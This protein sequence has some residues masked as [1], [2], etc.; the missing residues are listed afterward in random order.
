MLVKK[1]EVDMWNGLVVVL[2]LT[3]CSALGLPVLSH[4]T[5]KG[6]ELNLRGCDRCLQV[7]DLEV[8]RELDRMV[9]SGEISEQERLL[10]WQA[11]LARISSASREDPSYATK[12]SKFP[13][14]TG[15]GL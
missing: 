8:I 11:Y 3:V 13:V 4:A 14:F 1:G 15:P 10:L 5:S 6:N 7:K 2:A 12:K 9:K